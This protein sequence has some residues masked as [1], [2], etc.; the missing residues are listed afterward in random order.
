VVSGIR[1]LAAPVTEAYRAGERGEVRANEGMGG[2]VQ[3]VY[4]CSLRQPEQGT[5]SGE[6]NILKNMRHVF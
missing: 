1:T 2:D 5:I 3:E 4:A 6:T